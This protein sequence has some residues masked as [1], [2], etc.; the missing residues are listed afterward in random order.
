MTEPVPWSERVLL[1]GVD[2]GP[3]LRPAF[4]FP[5][6]W[7]ESGRRL[8]ASVSEAVL[9][10]AGTA[11]MIIGTLAG[12]A[13]QLILGGRLLGDIVTPLGG[14]AQFA[15]LAALIAAVFFLPDIIKDSVVGW[16]RA[17]ALTLVVSSLGRIE[18]SKSGD[19]LAGSGGMPGGREAGQWIDKNV[20]EGAKLMTI[21]PSMAM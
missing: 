13:I 5:N 4:A 3:A 11:A 14:A 7:Q 12:P 6:G 21:G 16:R 8:P 20:P 19:L 10:A 18:P 2:F 15:R 9:A 17:V 1:A